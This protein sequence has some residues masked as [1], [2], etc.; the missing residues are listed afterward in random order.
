MSF[1]ALELSPQASEILLTIVKTFVITFA[2]F[3]FFGVGIYTARQIRGGQL[4]TAA[5]M[6]VPLIV[7]PV[8]GWIFISCVIGLIYL[9]SIL[10][11]LVVLFGISGA[12][13]E[14]QRTF[15]VQFGFNRVPILKAMVWGMLVFGAIML[16]ETPLM[17]ASGWVLDYLDLPHPEQQA[18]ETFRQYNDFSTIVR[19]LF[20]AV[21]I[22]P[23]IE[24]LFFRGYLLTFLKNYTSTPLAIFF[25]AGI[26]AFA[27]LNL[28]VAAPLWFLGIVL[29]IAYEHTGSLLVPISIHACFNLATGLSILLD[30]SSPT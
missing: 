17:Q 25:S 13:M 27:H 23:A 8:A 14:N 26:F 29:G 9:Q 22:S 19:F 4:F 30:K 12:V 20:L 5:S 21:F 15:K 18:V 10:Y 11:V 16:V 2:L 6:P 28:G 24:E 3:S 1:F 7:R